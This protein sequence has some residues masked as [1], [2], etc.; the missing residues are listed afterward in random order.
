[1]T[2]T[3]SGTIEGNGQKW[4]ELP[5]KPHRVPA[6]HLFHFTFCLLA[7]EYLFIYV[8]SHVGRGQNSLKGCGNL[9]LVDVF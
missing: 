2:L 6:L 8:R 3:G 7:L 1:M 5:C 4:W 9:S